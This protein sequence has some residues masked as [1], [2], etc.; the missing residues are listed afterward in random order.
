[1]TGKKQNRRNFLKL[2]GASIVLGSIALWNNLV[3]TQKLLLSEKTKTLPFNPNEEVSF[4]DRFIVVKKKENIAVYSANCSHLGCNIRKFENGV[5]VC[6]C[7]GSRFNL[8]G[9]P[10]KG[11]AIKPLKKYKHTL[12]DAKHQLTV[13]L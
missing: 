1:M 7:H 2:A 8:E 4:V 11:P 9:K 6:P 13:T 3:K 5:F 10:V 12:D